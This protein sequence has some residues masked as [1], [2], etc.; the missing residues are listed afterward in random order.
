MFTK[1]T[2]HRVTAE[3]DGNV[4]RLAGFC[5]LMTK[6]G[7]HEVFS[8]NPEKTIN[9]ALTNICILNVQVF[10]FYYLSVSVFTV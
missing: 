10:N 9:Q 1:A 3:V 8:V 4:I 6:P 5:D 2:I 7:D